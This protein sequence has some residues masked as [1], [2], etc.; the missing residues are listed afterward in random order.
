MGAEAMLSDVKAMEAIAAQKLNKSKEATAQVK[1]EKLLINQAAVA[2]AKK[3][4]ELK[5]KE[6]DDGRQ[7]EMR[8]AREIA[9]EHAEQ[10]MLLAGLLLVTFFMVGLAITIVRLK[11]QCQSRKSLISR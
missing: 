7:R 1:A 9:W 3:E 2:V 6:R 11:K 4:R 10:R 8:M 5:K